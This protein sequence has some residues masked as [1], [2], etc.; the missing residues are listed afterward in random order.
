MAGI[1]VPHDFFPLRQVQR[2]ELVAAAIQP[3]QLA[4][5][6]DEQ[7]FQQIVLAVQSR[8]LGVLPQIQPPQIGV[9]A[10]EAHQLRKVFDS[11]QIPDTGISY[12][13]DLHR[14]QFFC[15]QH[16][17]LVRVLIHDTLTE[18]LVREVLLVDGHSF[19]Y[20]RHLE[21][22][23]KTNRHDPGVIVVG[24]LFRTRVKDHLAIHKGAASHIPDT[25]RV[26]PFQGIHRR[27][28][29]DRAGVI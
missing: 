14:V 18:Y 12:L 24:D 21:Y 4:L 9:V 16:A 5:R 19:P 2:R 23:R 15:R 7:F 26:D 13:E 25:L 27:S 6:A 28:L 20:Q 17:V 10:G 1:P 8:Q 11:R 29:P 22:F 3:P